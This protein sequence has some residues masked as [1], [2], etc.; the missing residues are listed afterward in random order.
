MLWPSLVIGPVPGTLSPCNLSSYPWDTRT[1]PNEP[2]YNMDPTSLVLIALDLC[3]IRD[4]KEEAFE[5][6]V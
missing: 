3:D 6:F 4:D 2:Q 1:S 5:Y